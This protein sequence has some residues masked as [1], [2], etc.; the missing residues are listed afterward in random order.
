MGVE[1]ERQRRVKGR[2]EGQR[3][4]ARTGSAG[5]ACGPYKRERCVE[6]QSWLL[7]QQVAATYLLENVQFFIINS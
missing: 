4:R 2:V 1:S 7:A 3:P 5:G 6:R